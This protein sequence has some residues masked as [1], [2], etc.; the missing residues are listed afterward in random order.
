MDEA[1]DLEYGIKKL[2]IEIANLE[3]RLAQKKKSGLLYP[4]EEEELLGQIENRKNQV[5]KLESEIRRIQ[6]TRIRGQ[7]MNE[8]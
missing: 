3:K 1:K 8:A 2:N 4:E 5:S 7:N 6:N